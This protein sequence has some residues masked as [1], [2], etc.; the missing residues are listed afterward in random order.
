MEE[1]V[2]CVTRMNVQSIQI[3]ARDKMRKTNE[4][5]VLKKKSNK[6]LHCGD[7]DMEERL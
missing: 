4:I 3:M 6:L 2:G 1:Y 7:R 5:Q